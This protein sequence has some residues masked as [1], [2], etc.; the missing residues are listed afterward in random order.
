MHDEK[1]KDLKDS[2]QRLRAKSR[3]LQIRSAALRKRASDLY[4]DSHNVSLA[5]I[6]ELDLL[7]S[8]GYFDE[9]PRKLAR[10]QK[11]SLNSNRLR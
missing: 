3:D 10:D 1:E 6:R 11:L 2:L 5:P 4:R 7:R 8:L 9:P